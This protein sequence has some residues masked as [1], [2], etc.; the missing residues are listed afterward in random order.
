MQTKLP[1]MPEQ[2][3]DERYVLRCGMKKFINYKKD[4]IYKL[5]K[6]IKKSVIK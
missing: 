4:K 1:V 2:W 5:K 6:E 3:V